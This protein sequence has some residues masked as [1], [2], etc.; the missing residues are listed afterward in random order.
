ML[1]VGNGIDSAGRRFC[2]TLP[3]ASIIIGP[4]NSSTNRLNRS[5]VVTLASVLRASSKIAPTAVA[6]TSVSPIDFSANF[7]IAAINRTSQC[8]ACHVVIKVN[9]E[10]PKCATCGYSL[11]M[12]QSGICPECGTPVPRFTGSSGQAVLS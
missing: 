6:N 11:L 5:G 1:D 2:T 3:S 10:E 7:T 12:L 4:T 8:E 9:V